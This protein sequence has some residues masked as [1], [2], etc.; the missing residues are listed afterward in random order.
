M[1]T[2]TVAPLLCL[3]PNPEVTEQKKAV[4]YASSLEK[5]GTGHTS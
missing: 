3:L 5:Q 2:T 1:Y 4:V